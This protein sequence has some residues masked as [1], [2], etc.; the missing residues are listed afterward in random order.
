MVTSEGA[1]GGQ[2]DKKGNGEQASKSRK[3]S[4][5][6]HGLTACARKVG[7]PPSLFACPLFTWRP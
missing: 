2:S 1:A 5:P 6:G 7:A 4:R 3:G